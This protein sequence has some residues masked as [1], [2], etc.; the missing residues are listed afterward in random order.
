M[1]TAVPAKSL[2]VFRCLSFFLSVDFG[3]LLFFVIQHDR[4]NLLSHQPVLH[5]CFLLTV[6]GVVLFLSLQKL[7]I[8][9]VQ[10]PDAGQ[11]LQ[12]SFIESLLGRFVEGQVLPVRFKI[13]LAESAGFLTLIDLPCFD[14]VQNVSSQHRNL[15]KA[16][17]I[18][19]D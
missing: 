4:Y 2:T 16:S 6:L 14:I 9:G 3:L 8:L 19:S 15:G 18:G 12:V 5:L 7:C 17:F 1:R 10:V 11:L 13:Y